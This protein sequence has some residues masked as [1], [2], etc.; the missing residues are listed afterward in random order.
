MLP[1]VTEGDE[2]GNCQPLQPPEEVHQVTKPAEIVAALANA[3][4]TNIDR[5]TNRNTQK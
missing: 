3:D 5:T 1:A 2:D 4:S